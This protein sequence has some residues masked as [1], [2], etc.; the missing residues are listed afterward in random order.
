M[1]SL[2]THQKS[3]MPRWCTA[4]FLFFVMGIA[5][6]GPTLAPIASIA[7][8]SGPVVDRSTLAFVSDNLIAIAR[9]PGSE[10]AFSAT[11]IAVEL[12][13]GKVRPLQ[14]YSVSLDRAAVVG[15]LYAVAHGA[16]LSKLTR[17]PQLLSWQPKETAGVPLGITMI[18]PV[19]QAGVV[20][21]QQMFPHWNWKL[22]RL[23]P[24][25]SLVRAGTGEILSVSDEFIVFRGDQD[26]RIEGID[27]TDEGSF[28]VPARSTCDERATILGR[29]RLL[30]TD[31]KKEDRVVDF[32]GKEL[33]RLPP[34][35]GW[36][37]RL[38]QSLD[39][40]RVL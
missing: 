35:D 23:G 2:M 21:D 1:S 40:S 32:H 22:Y 26:I 11:I 27:G 12:R 8:N 20:A 36:N 6:A 7:L 4:V 38:G 9:Y 31:C 17:T 25:L 28:Q 29:N 5:A 34:R 18:P 30:V 39:G 33:V 13:D 24:P 14:K 10:G 15:E 37:H 3:P 16:I 19:H